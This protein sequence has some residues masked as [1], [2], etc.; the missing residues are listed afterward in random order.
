MRRGQR[1]H[2]RRARS[3]DP[4]LQDRRRHLAARTGRGCFDLPINGG[5][6][7]RPYLDH[8]LRRRRAVFYYNFGILCGRNCMSEFQPGA[9]AAFAA[10]RMGTAVVQ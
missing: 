10:R 8:H 9:P 1:R 4:G 7:L 3:S 6:K 2:R 5:S